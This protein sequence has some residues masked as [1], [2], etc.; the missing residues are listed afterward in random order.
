[1][2]TFG[3]EF[4]CVCGRKAFVQDG[5]FYVEFLNY[6]ERLCS[7]ECPNR[8]EVELRAVKERQRKAKEV[9]AKVYGEKGQ[10]C[11]VPDVRKQILRRG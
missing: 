7:S 9:E 1:M 5:N 3:V 8:P 6:E 2:N 4:V 11:F 10:N